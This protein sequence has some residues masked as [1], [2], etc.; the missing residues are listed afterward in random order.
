ME[1]NQQ[2]MERISDTWINSFRVST[3]D[4]P[5]DFST[6]S[7]TLGS[8]TTTFNPNAFALITE[9]RMELAYYLTATAFPIFPNPTTPKV[10]P[11]RR[12]APLALKVFH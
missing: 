2:L 5:N 9:Q 8:C 3:L 10:C 4:T 6:P 7:S 11:R 1:S 12:V